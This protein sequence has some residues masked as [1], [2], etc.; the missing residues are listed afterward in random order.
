MILSDR[1]AEFVC[2][3]EVASG[4]LIFSRLKDR[5]DRIYIDE[6]QDMAGHDL[7]LLEGMM[8]AGANVTLV[9]DHRQP[10]FRTNYSGKNSAFAG[11]KIIDKFRQWEK[12]K[13]CSL[14]Y[15]THTYRCNQEITDFADALYKAEPPTK[16]MNS[17]RTGHDGVFCIAST[18]VDSYVQKFQPRILRYD[19]NSLCA[20]YD[21]MNFG[22][23]KGLTFDRVL[24]FP[25]GKMATWLGTGV[26]AHVDG[27][28]AKTY[29]AITRARY[30]VAFV[31]DKP[32]ALPGVLTYQP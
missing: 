7:E 9:G 26:D 13:L 5:F 30:S 29:V 2:A 21:A 10:T 17:D 1:L 19:K 15:R 6:I 24:I 4:G 11:Y 25:T 23:S 14:D 3:C 16:S 8:R 12:L 31:L 27:S 18:S 32:S 20:G 22:M 28:R